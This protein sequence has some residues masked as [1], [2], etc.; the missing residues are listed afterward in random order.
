MQRNSVSRPSSSSPGILAR[1]ARWAQENKRGLRNAAAL[2][3]VIAVVYYYFIRRR[4]LES[5]IVAQLK[6]LD[7]KRHSG[8]DGL[9]GQQAYTDELEALQT[10]IEEYTASYNLDIAKARVLTQRAGAEWDEWES[11][12]TFLISGDLH[13]SVEC[14][15]D[16]C[17]NV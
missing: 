14:N 10:S 9:V 11:M 13:V 12:W 16:G 7:A 1:A 15:A 6:S 5:N 4:M 8:K 17:V 3:V 2:V